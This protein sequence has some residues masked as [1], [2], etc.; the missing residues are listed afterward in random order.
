MLDYNVDSDD[1]WEDEESGESLRDSEEEKEPV[2]DYEID[3]DIFV[4]HGYL[5]DGEGVEE[6]DSVRITS[7]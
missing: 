4:P 5:S 1:E 6:P 2:D 7:T 3:D